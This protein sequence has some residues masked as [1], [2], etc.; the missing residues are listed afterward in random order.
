MVGYV[1]NNDYTLTL[2][3]CKLARSPEYGG[4]SG[5]FTAEPRLHILFHTVPDFLAH[6]RL[7]G[8]TDTSHQVSS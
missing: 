5:G 4:A 1:C 2:P 6:R 7:R 8:P 3:H